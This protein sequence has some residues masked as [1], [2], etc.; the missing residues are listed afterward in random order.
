MSEGGCGLITGCGGFESISVQ[1]GDN[2]TTKQTSKPRSLYFHCI[3]SGSIFEISGN[4]SKP[5]QPV[6]SPHHPPMIRF[7]IIQETYK[8]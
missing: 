5:P 1:V 2:R 4:V 7:I 3:V 6:I 8:K